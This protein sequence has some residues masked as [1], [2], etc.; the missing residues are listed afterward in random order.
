MTE[1]YDTDKNNAPKRGA[2]SSG[3]MGALVLGVLL[4]VGI[5]VFASLFMPDYLR[6]G[7][8]SDLAK[9]GGMLASARILSVSETGRW[10]AKK[11]I[12]QFSVEV[13]PA[14]APEFSTHFEQE[15]SLM[16]VG[17]FRTGAVVQLRYN[18]AK[19][20]EAVIVNQPVP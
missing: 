15:I 4:A 1:K 11:P 8:Q 6:R 5:G 16:Q 18:P 20:S 3:V 9:E 13:S 12:L 14:E 19:P 10:Y 7:L 17:H 2:M